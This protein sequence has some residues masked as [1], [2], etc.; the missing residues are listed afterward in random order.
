MTKQLE[1]TDITQTAAAWVARLDSG[2]LSGEE[3]I[4]LRDWATASP[5]HMRELERLA[6]IWEGLD[7]LTALQSIMIRPK[8]E[9][10]RSIRN[11]TV[12]AGAVAAVFL[13]AALIYISVPERPAAVEFEKAFATEVG[14]Q[15]SIRPGEGSTI[16]LNTNS[17]LEVEYSAERRLVR[18]THG[19]AFFDVEPGDARPFV[20]ETEFGNVLVT[21]TMFL[22]RL[23]DAAMEVVVEEGSVQLKSNIDGG[24]AATV[25]L[26]ALTSGEVARLE[27]GGRRS[28]E[29]IEPERLVRRLGWRDG[30]LIFDGES[31]EEVISEVGRYTPIK[32]TIDD[33]ELRRRRIGGYFRIGEM[34]DLLATL[35]S[36][37]DIEVTRI[38]DNEVRLAVRRD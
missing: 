16:S 38:G 2:E 4:E 29:P 32:I 6:D 1:L 12:A 10:Y 31:L 19:E 23:E 17:E 7:R 24:G 13:A 27:S 28:I 14:E 8:P 37:F 36:D 15:Q 5:A 25:P 30:T 3:L 26:T 34:D 33:P 20:V 9:R 11:L 18:L 35:A 22:V 21:G